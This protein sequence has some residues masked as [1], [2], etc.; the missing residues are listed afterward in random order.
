MTKRQ[1]LDNDNTDVD[2]E[3]TTIKNNDNN[4]AD[5][6]P[7]YTNHY[8][9]SYMHQSIVSCNPITSIKHGYI[10]TGDITG[11]V[12]FWKRIPIDATSI[13][14]SSSTT[15]L[16]N[17]KSASSS[18]CCVEFVKSFIAHNGPV[19]CLCIDPIGDVCVSIGRNNS[20]SSSTTYM[21]KWYDVV[22]FDVTHMTTTTLSLGL[23]CCIFRMKSSGNQHSLAISSMNTNHIYIFMIDQPNCIQTISFHVGIITSL[24]Y[25]S[26]HDCIISTDNKGFIEVWDS[27]GVITT[28]TTDLTTNTTDLTP[29]TSSSTSITKPVTTTNDDMIHDEDDDDNNNDYN[30]NQVDAS[31]K[32]TTTTTTT[33]LVGT[34]CSYKKHQ[35]QYIS[36]MDTDFINLLKK[37]IYVIA[38]AITTM[39]TQNNQKE[40]E[41]TVY[42]MYCNDHKIRIYNHTTG[43]LIQFIDERRKVYDKLLLSSS[44]QQQDDKND[45][46]NNNHWWIPLDHMEYGKRIAVENE[47]QNETN[48]FTGIMTTNNNSQQQDQQQQ[49]CYQ[50]YRIQFDSMNYGKFLLVPSMMG[51]KVWDWNNN[52]PFVH[53]I[54]GQSDCTSLRY[55]NFCIA[56]GNANINQQMQLARQ[57][58]LY[59]T[60]QSNKND[61]DN[62]ENDESNHIIPN[63]SLIVAVAYNQR[64]IYIF[65]HYDPIDDIVSTK[66]QN[67]LHHDNDNNNNQSNKKK[68]HNK[69]NNSNNV[70]DIATYRDVWN[71]APTVQ[72]QLYHNRQ[73]TQHS[74]DPLMNTKHGSTTNTSQ[75]NNKAILR[76]TMGDIH[77]QLHNTLTPKTVE[78]FIGHSQSGYYDNVIFHRVIVNFMI[79]TGDPLGDGT[80]GESIWGHEFDDEI[81][82]SLKHDTSFIVSMANAGKNTNGSQFFITT[83]ITPWLD[84]KHTIFGKVIK[85]MDICTQI[86]HVQ[87]DD[88]DKPLN[89]I[90]IINI[91]IV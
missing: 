42:A 39:K 62:N 87:T 59:D 83:S 79:Q 23:S 27:S 1:R 41:I 90:R 25:L 69:K 31:N 35:I 45:N 6:I 72:D 57:Q 21:I 3:A 73:Q 14:S 18:S 13:V 58:Q 77:I 17:K 43:K 85:G 52:K 48:I 74:T 63:D 34:A 38:V 9:V 89:D 86:E 70:D 49:H 82:S 84:G 11:I 78:N 16:N 60:N 53:S 65:S 4:I 71:E 22:T 36:K 44:S 8:H 15:K 51:I 66:N 55:I 29:P 68:N 12:K 32:T 64:R 2:N 47:I 50:R 76:T 67:G 46:G 28:T 88:N 54:I 61:N 24:T 5:D 81:I 56:P 19:Q 91:D 10:I 30:N 7:I 33:T 75:S 80:G 37:K 40:K 20:T 26:N